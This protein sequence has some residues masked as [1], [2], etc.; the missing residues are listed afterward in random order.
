[1]R[2]NYLFDSNQNKTNKGIEAII[3]CEF[4]VHLG[5]VLKYQV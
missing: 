5:P 3:F 2:P 4:D 1:M